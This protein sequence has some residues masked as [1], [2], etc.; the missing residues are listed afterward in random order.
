M[1]LINQNTQ[2]PQNIT[3][4]SKYQQMSGKYISLGEL[5]SLQQNFTGLNQNINPK[6]QRTEELKKRT[7]NIGR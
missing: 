3:F 1:K 4:K 6:D 2:H 5:S 7:K